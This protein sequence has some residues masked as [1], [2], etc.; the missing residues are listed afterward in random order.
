MASFHADKQT[1]KKVLSRAWSSTFSDVVGRPLIVDSQ[2][3]ALN[4]AAR[5]DEMYLTEQELLWDSEVCAVGQLAASAVIAGAE[6][7]AT[8]AKAKIGAWKLEADA[9]KSLMIRFK[10]RESDGVP[11]EELLRDLKFRR[12]RASSKLFK[13]LNRVE[14]APDQVEE[15]TRMLETMCATL[16]NIS[17][18]YV[19]LAE[20]KTELSVIFYQLQEAL[21]ELLRE[22]EESLLPKLKMM[23]AL[24]I[25][26]T[27]RATHII[28]GAR[29][30][31]VRWVPRI[32]LASLVLARSDV[33]S[34]ISSTTVESVANHIQDKRLSDAFV[35]DE[36]LCDRVQVAARH[37]AE[38]L[39]NLTP[40]SARALIAHNQGTFSFHKSVA[41]SHVRFVPGVSLVTT[42]MDAA[43]PSMETRANCIAQVQAES[44]NIQSILDM[45]NTRS[46]FWQV[47]LATSRAAPK[48]GRVSSVP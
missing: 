19:E 15:A 43:S 8:C 14:Q 9:A 3:F 4:L 11:I 31:R 20:A 13:W 7:A 22:R 17:D 10:A 16:S 5:I 39:D 23:C 44:G 48:L 1:S 18:D 42:F 34:L 29:F 45:V 25:R 41:R 38:H 36:V 12:E 30:R 46:D 28:N 47:H 35:K 6:V 21:H 33:R 2:T 24:T 37:L 26:R 40:L 32:I 27:G